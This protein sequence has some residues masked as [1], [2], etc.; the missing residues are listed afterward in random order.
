MNYTDLHCDTVSRCFKEKKS[1]YDS[2]L[3]IN[4]IKTKGIENYR[5]FFAL[6]L[7]DELQ[8]KAA[9]SLCKNMLDYYEAEIV[10][11]ISECKNIWAHLSI[12][13]ASALGG[14]VGNVAYF[15]DRGVGIMSLTWN[16]ENDLASGTD[17]KG[18]LKPMGRQVVKEMARYNM[19][20]DVSHLN[21]ESFYDVCLTDSIRIIATH[22]N[23]YDICKHKRNLKKW[24]IKELI[25]RD[26]LIGINFYPPFLGTGRWGVF[27]KIRDNISYLLSMGGENCIALGSDFDGAEMAEELSGIDKVESLYG[28]RIS[29][30]LS[31]REAKKIFYRNAEKIM[32]C[33]NSSV[34]P[35]VCHL[36][37]QGRQ[38]KPSLKEKWDR[39]SGG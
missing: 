28:Y 10:P 8:G 30:G 37:Y 33:D 1:F 20:L 13:N 3:Q 5:Q 15:K 14:D 29:E 35:S 24:Q 18:G 6:W 25:S 19:T 38:N 26:G 27:E 39:F 4:A 31:E 34:R 17:A 21:E 2:D 9:F 7:S 11:I 22:S 16:G 36:P 32:N 23:C 12:E